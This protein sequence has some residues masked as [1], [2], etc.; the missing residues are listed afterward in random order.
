MDAIQK[1]IIVTSKVVA[2]L[3]KI[4]YITMIITVCFEAAGIIWL[5]ISPEVNSITLGG[6][7]IIWP[8][9]LAND[10]GIGTDLLPGVAS[11]CF[12]IAILISANRIFRNVSCEYSPFTPKIAKGMKRIALLLLIDSGVAP[13]VDFEIKKA[14]SLTTDNLYDFSS[15]LMILAI[16]IYCF[17][18]IFQY[19][20]E[21]QQQ[22]DETL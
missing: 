11:Q 22:S 3:T 10:V 2:V 6:I 12:F 9:S 21:L 5:I 16:V 14:I 19:G 8:F 13:R 15:E 1:K 17:S 20:M 18:L 7:R 4:L